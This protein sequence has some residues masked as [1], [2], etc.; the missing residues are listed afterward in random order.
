MSYGSS[1]SEQELVE[2]FTGAYCVGLIIGLAINIAIIIIAVKMAE[3]RGRS[4]AAWGFL[5]FLIGLLAIII[6]ACIGDSP[7]K[8]RADAARAEARRRRQQ[9][10]QQEQQSST[11]FMHNYPSVP[12]ERKSAVIRIVTND[13]PCPHCGAN[14]AAFPCPFCGGNAPDEKQEQNPQDNPQE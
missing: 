3:K 7:D 9:E 10:H 6:L 2:L 11:S 12:T 14:I 13:K 5:A 4:G 8:V 1:M